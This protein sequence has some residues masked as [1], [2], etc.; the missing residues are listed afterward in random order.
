MTK[1]HLILAALATYG[2]LMTSCSQDEM[3]PPEGNGVVTFKATLPGQAFSRADGEASGETPSVFGDGKKATV[4]K[5]AVYEAGED[6]V[7]FS[8][9]NA[10]DPQGIYQKNDWGEGYITYG[11]DLTLKLIKGKSYDIIFWAQHEDATCYEFSPSEKQV[12]VNYEGATINDETRDAFFGVI[13][14]YT[15]KEGT[16]AETQANLCRPFA[17]FNV[18][19]NDLAEAKRAMNIPEEKNFQTKVTVKDVPTV[20]NLLTGEASTNQEVVTFGCGTPVSDQAFPV[21]AKEGEK[22]YTYMAMNYVL[23]GAV[24]KAEDI[25]QADKETKDIEIEFLDP[26]NT[27]CRTMPLSAV[28]FQ[29]NH[30]TNIYGSLFTS[31]LTIYLDIMPDFFKTTYDNQYAVETFEELQTAIDNG[32]TQIVLKNDIEVPEYESIIIRDNSK[33]QRINLDG[34]TLTFKENPRN[35]EIIPGII[36]ANV[37]ID[38]VNQKVSYLMGGTGL[39]PDKRGKIISERSCRAIEALDSRI[40]LYKL[41]IESTSLTN[42]AGRDNMVITCFGGNLY[43]NEVSVN[44]NASN[45]VYLG[46]D[47]TAK[48][49][50][51]KCNFLQTW[52]P[53]T[54]AGYVFL[55]QKHNEHHTTQ[56]DTKGNAKEDEAGT[57]T[58]TDCKTSSYAMAL[59]VYMSSAT[60][61]PNVTI[62]NCEAALFGETYPNGQAKSTPTLRL[63]TAGEITLTGSVIYNANPTGASLFSRSTSCTIS[64]SLFSVTPQLNNTAIEGFTDVTETR[65]LLTPEGESTEVTLTKQI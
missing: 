4:L 3:A 64:S 31:D 63:D 43:M 8:S 12:S 1:K 21:Q 52:V 26:A 28:P 51:T 57:I 5:Y 6:V 9:E 32:A 7:I 27:T 23:T 11:F 54:G 45:T 40:Y 36:Y 44:T 56:Y 33:L 61:Q 50:I 55:Y 20:L 34:H 65:T 19:I 60:Y 46:T 16:N 35:T 38:G 53:E 30:R 17:Q 24:P 62:T 47:G 42:E 10:D 13:K 14:G 59:A 29:R 25:A 48:A 2:L 41:D 49:T 39:E 22:P 18:G 15:V 37:A 58:F